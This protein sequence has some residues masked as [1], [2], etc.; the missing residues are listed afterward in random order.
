[1]ATPRRRPPRDP[2]D[3]LGPGERRVHRGH[4]RPAP[5]LDGRRGPRARPGVPDP[6]RGA[7]RPA[8]TPE[9]HPLRPPG[10]AADTLRELPRTADPR[11]VRIPPRPGGRGAGVGSRGRAHGRRAP[12]RAVPAHPADLG[13][14]RTGRR[15]ARARG[16]A[17]R[18][19]RRGPAR[20]RHPGVAGLESDDGGAGPPPGGGRGGHRGHPAE[21]DRHPGRRSGRPR[22]PRGLRGRSPAQDGPLPG[23]PGPGLP[24]RTAGRG[25]RLRGHR[26]RGGGPRP[27]PGHRGRHRH[28]PA[29]PGP[30]HGGTGGRPGRGCGPGSVPLPPVA[31]AVHRVRTPFVWED[32]EIVAGTEIL[33]APG[34][35]PAPKGG[36]GPGVW[37]SP[38]CGAPGACAATRLAVLVAEE[39]VLAITAVARPF[40][41][42]P[43]PPPAGC[44]ARSR[45][46]R[47]SSRSGNSRA[48][49]ATAG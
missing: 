33:C 35:L 13:D 46:G 4:G 44:R 30:A 43:R 14:R 28:D 1:M 5:A 18:R 29:G 11:S 27:R 16:A 21:R 8:G 2:R 42:S 25:G 47:C 26:G 7:A 23:E 49:G 31:A 19:G 38:L 15:T 9:A 6:R 17:R 3:G 48:A 32:L 36:A 37:P 20:G 12:V 45:R 39:L 22:C 40:L 41:V 10:P 24:G 34:W